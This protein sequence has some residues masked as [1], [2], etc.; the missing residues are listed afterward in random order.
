MRNWVKTFWLSALLVSASHIQM[1]SANGSSEDEIKAEIQQVLDNYVVAVDTLDMS[2]AKS[3]WSMR[4]DVS[5]IQPR[6]HQKGWEDIRDSFYGKAMGSF[7]VRKL[8]LRDVNIRV[9]SDDTAWADF[10]WDFEATFKD[11]TPA[12]TTGRETQVFSKEA[13]GWKIVHIHYSGPATQREREGF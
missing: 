4:E 6:G 9:L 11:G 5:F 12:E 1:A 13:D 3:I 2:V 10:Y 8:M 7:S